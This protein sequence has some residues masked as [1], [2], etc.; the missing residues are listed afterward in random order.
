MITNTTTR[1]PNNLLDGL[2]P[3]FTGW[4]TDPGTNADLVDELTDTLTTSGVQTNATTSTIIYDLGSSKRII[5][6]LFRGVVVTATTFYLN[7]SDDNV[8]YYSIAN[9]TTTTTERQIVGIGKG[10]YIQARFSSAAAG[11]TIANLKIRAYRL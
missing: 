11:N 3:T 2:T 10:R 4:N 5:G 7:I 9:Y 8:T 6:W 1:N